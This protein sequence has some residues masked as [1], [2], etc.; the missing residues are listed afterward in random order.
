M[1]KDGKYI[2]CIIASSYE[3]NFGNIG[4]GGKGDLVTTIGYDGICMVVSDH[5]LSHYVVNPENI[6]SH[7]KVIERVMSE[8][9][10]VLPVRF[11]TVAATPDEIRN[12]INRRYSELSELL[13]QF[14]NKIEYN[15]RG[16]WHDMNIIYKEIDAE[17]PALHDLKCEIDA[18]ENIQEKNEKIKKAGL[19]LEECLKK[20]KNNELDDITGFFKRSVFEYKHNKLSSETMF[21]NTAFLINKGRELEIDNIMN[22]LGEKYQDRSDFVY[23]G[24]LPIFNFIDLRI[25]PERWEI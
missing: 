1:Q 19:I 7:Q 13:V 10:S 6:L 5:T 4:I 20:K 8:Y 24:P 22:N 21:M 18:L 25:L 23:T 9:N 16:V 2:Y 3:S 12:L 15:V 17:N 14:E 11:G